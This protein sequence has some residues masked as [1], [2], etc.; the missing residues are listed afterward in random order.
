MAFQCVIVTPEAQVFDES[1][2]QAI[3]PAHDGQIGIL[4]D[5]APLLVKLGVGALQLDMAAGQQRRTLFI[6][7]GI[8][9]MK[10][11]KLTIVTNEALNPPDIDAETARAELAE[12]TAR[13]ATDEK[14]AHD[15]QRRMQRARVMQEMARK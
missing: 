1:V 12:A 2:T 13:V 6:E 15:R 14:S 11:N 5:R 10:D 7:G 9:Q 8:A 3:I 4:T